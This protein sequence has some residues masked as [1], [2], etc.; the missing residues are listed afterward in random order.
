MFQD[1][2]PDSVRHLL[3]MQEILEVLLWSEWL[4]G[5]DPLVHGTRDPLDHTEVLARVDL[6]DDHFVLLEI[7]SDVAGPLDGDPLDLPQVFPVT[8]GLGSLDPVGNLGGDL[9]DEGVVLAVFES[10]KSP[11]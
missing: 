3:N 8:D 2:L 9:V 11:G 4:G 1:S 6:L 10:L 7:S 5:E